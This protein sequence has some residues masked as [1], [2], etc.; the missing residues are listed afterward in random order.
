M[1]LPAVNRLGPVI[2]LHRKISDNPYLWKDTEWMA[3]DC[4]RCVRKLMAE[5]PRARPSTG[6]LVTPE[7]FV[8]RR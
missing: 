3:N 4:E 2:E 7:T 6:E 5:D 8:N 1:I